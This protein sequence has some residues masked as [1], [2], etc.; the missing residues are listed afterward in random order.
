MSPVE[1]ENRHRPP[2]L[3][4]E[5]ED[6]N[7]SQSKQGLPAWANIGM[8]LFCAVYLINPTLGVI[9]FIPD[10]LPIIGNLDEATATAGLL[11][12]LSGL[13]LIPWARK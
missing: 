7:E 13:G 12:A 11:Y 6:G 4:G 5:L 1:P 10:N 9:E 8:A 2:P 3:K